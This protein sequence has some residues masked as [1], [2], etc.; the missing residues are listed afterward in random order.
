MNFQNPHFLNQPSCY[1]R[2]GRKCEYVMRS[3]EIVGLRCD[4][5]KVSRLR[6]NSPCAAYLINVATLTVTDEGL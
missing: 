1:L 6:G 2:L 3:L 4:C 5:R